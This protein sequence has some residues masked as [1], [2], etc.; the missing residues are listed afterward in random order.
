MNIEKIVYTG[1]IAD[2]YGGELRTLLFSNGYDFMRSRVEGKCKN[3]NRA[4]IVIDIPAK[5]AWIEYVDD[6]ISVYD[7][8]RCA[9]TCDIEDVKEFLK[10]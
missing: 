8:E 9:F 10:Q 2:F 4:V 3:C 6:D 1:A 7:N 5:F